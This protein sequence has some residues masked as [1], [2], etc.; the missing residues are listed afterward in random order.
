[1]CIYTHTHT[2]ILYIVVSDV[3]R[4]AN[5]LV[6]E[7]KLQRIKGRAVVRVW[8]YRYEVEQ[9]VEEDEEFGTRGE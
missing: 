8:Y 5:Y 1:M 6:N 7:I 9:K 3:A 2:P 4:R